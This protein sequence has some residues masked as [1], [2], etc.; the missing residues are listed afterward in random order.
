MKKNI[1]PVTN[2]AV[3]L[4]SF[5]AEVAATA[6]VT[7]AKRIRVVRAQL[8]TY[9]DQCGW[10]SLTTGQLGLLR[11]EQQFNPV[12]AYARIAKAEDLFYTLQHFLEPQHRLPALADSRY[13]VRIIGELAEWMRDHDLFDDWEGM[14]CE[15]IDLSIALTNAR[16]EL[17]TPAKR[18]GGAAT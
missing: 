17:A 7:T 8:D 11:G 15:A 2:V 18:G 16:S 12:G 3:L 14:S 1:T 10:R 6:S 5:F 4:D 13:Q 9:L